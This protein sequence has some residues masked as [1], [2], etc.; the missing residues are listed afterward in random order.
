M[1]FLIALLIPAFA[2]A[3]P[4]SQRELTAD[5]IKNGAGILLLP[6]SNDTLVGRATT[7][8]FT[9]KTFDAAGT[10]NVLSNVANANVAAGAAID[11]SKLAT[12][13]NGNIL[14]G[15]GSNVATSVAPSGDIALSNAGVLT[16]NNLVPI[17]KGGLNNNVA[18]TAGGMLYSDGT[19]FVNMGA[20]TAGQVPVSAAGSPPV[21][22]TLARPT[23]QQFTTTGST[24]GYWFTVSSANATVG[25]TYTNNGNTYTVLSTIA[26][27]LKL[28][29]S[30]ASAIR[31]DGRCNDQLC[32]QQHL[33]SS[34]N[35]GGL[36]S[37]DRN[38]I[39]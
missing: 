37:Y 11:F 8:T 27:G 30:G 21:W 36:H 28:Y 29:V 31:R 16:Y 34:R 26:S 23:V 38:Q 4:S 3:M 25:A 18:A 7:D 9:H 13:T 35:I 14:I 20:G 32:R 1:K 33:F 15:N 10:G 5:H 22:T 39:G 24:A 12:L 2:F 6:T 19:K 17:A